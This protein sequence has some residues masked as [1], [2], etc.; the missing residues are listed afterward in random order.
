MQIRL[1]RRN[2]RR[3]RSRR[4]PYCKPKFK[5]C[6]VSSNP[7]NSK[8]VSEQVQT[9]APNSANSPKS[10]GQ[11]ARQISGWTTNCLL[12]AMLLVVAL[13][14][15]RVVLHWWRAPA[16][17]GPG[18]IAAADSLGDPSAPHVL[19]F[20][21]QAWS[22]E[23]HE[24]SGTAPGVQSALQE[25]C[26]AVIAVAWPRGDS[27]DASEREMLKRLAKEKP[28]AEKLGQWRLYQWGEERSVL[29]G[30]RKPAGRTDAGTILDETTFRVVIWGIAV[31][32]AANRWTLYLFRAGGDG[33]GGEGQRSTDIP[34]PPGGRRLVAIRAAARGSITAFSVAD[35][36]DARG[37]Y[38][39]WFAEHGWTAV[40]AWRPSATGWNARYDLRSDGS[41]SAVDVRLG[42]DSQGSWSGLVMVSQLERGRP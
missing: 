4:F 39:R 10:L 30:T 28:I 31:P 23:R 21:N 20:G 9:R 41:E 24:F 13:V 15:G 11:L 14:V 37:F 8:V 5:S 19:E 27:A 17:T 25:A 2:W 36:N 40:A 32:V 26:R 6:K 34:L 42:I 29:I 22:I 35:G 38:D 18:V 7:F 16:A 3:S 33:G 12:T 1:S